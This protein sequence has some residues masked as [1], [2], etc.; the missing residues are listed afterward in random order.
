MNLPSMITILS[1]HT[2]ECNHLAV[3]SASV[4][5]KLRR[6]QMNMQVKIMVRKMAIKSAMST[7]PSSLRYFSGLILLHT[8]LWVSIISLECS[9]SCL[10]IGSVTTLKLY[11]SKGLLLSH[12][13]Q[14]SSTQPSFSYSSTQI[15]VNKDS[16]LASPM[17]PCQISIVNGSKQLVHP[18]S[19]LCSSMHFTHFLK[20]L[21]TGAWD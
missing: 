7:T 18:W 12:G 10:S 9:V 1:N 6:I 13:L 17:E 21:V 4:N 16:P 3:F 8:S 15:G 2:Q 19:T 20:L 5:S 14:H 11:D